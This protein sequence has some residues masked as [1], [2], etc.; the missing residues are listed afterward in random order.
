MT[1]EGL[2]VLQDSPGAE[3]L[4]GYFEAGVLEQALP[5]DVRA[6]PLR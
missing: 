3:N 4:I 5:A 6:P 1:G 2:R